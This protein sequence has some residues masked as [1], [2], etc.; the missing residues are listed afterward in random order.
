MRIRRLAIIPARNDEVNVPKM[1]IR[2]E[3]EVVRAVI[4][5]V[6]VRTRRASRLEVVRLIPMDRMC[7]LA[8]IQRRVVA[9]A[10]AVLELVGRAVEGAFNV[11]PSAAA[12]FPIH[13]ETDAVADPHAVLLAVGYPLHDGVFPVALVVGVFLEV[14]AVVDALWAVSI[15]IGSFQVLQVANIR[16]PGRYIWLQRN[17]S[18]CH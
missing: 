7:M 1:R 16:I 17:R 10:V 14:D 2:P 8:G 9:V 18:E 6:N 13:L 4:V 15:C 11:S 12:T 3:L 5:T